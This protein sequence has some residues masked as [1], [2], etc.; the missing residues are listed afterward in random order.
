[1]LYYKK[2]TEI[3]IVVGLISAIALPPFPLAGME[4]YLVTPIS[5]IIFLLFLYNFFRFYVNI[6]SIS[7]I[8][9]MGLVVIFS[10]L[11]SWM[12]DYSKPINSD[13][14]EALK[15]I[16]FIPY[17]LGLSVVGCFSN[18][19]IELIL[20]ISSILVLF[21]GFFQ[22]TNF[23][24]IGDILSVIYIGENSNHIE[25]VRSGERLT[26]TGSDPNVGAVICLFYMMWY[27]V[28]FNQ[29]NKKITNLLFCI[30]FFYLV[31]LTQSRTALVAL[32][33]SLIIYL[34]VY[35][36]YKFIWK[37]NLFFLMLSFVIAAVY[38][39]NLEYIILG[40]SMALDGDNL[41]LLTRFE[42]LETA[43]TKFSY[44]PFFGI[45]PSKSILQHPIDS[46]YALI[47]QRYGLVG[48]LI[49][50]LYIF[51][52]IKLSSRLINSNYGI[53]L[54]LFVQL[55][56]IVMLTNNIFSGYQLMSIVVFLNIVCLS[57]SRFTNCDN[58]IG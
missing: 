21:V 28:K 35:S 43:L 54:F 34:F 42:N 44:S 38:L 10:S 27:A 16:Q 23:F 46:E 55:S 40:F 58:S 57:H 4:Y 12:N 24:N 49:F 17:I 25:G 3:L 52:L 45:G 20:A 8:A 33:Y 30:C 6:K 22:Q 51:Y 9:A 15:Y 31:L 1:M 5:A 19:M 50:F 41:S 32:I 11:I 47:L 7:Y 2:I 37:L 26:I 48:L 18:K 39:L 13:L 56:F 14:I 36:K 29:E 53:M